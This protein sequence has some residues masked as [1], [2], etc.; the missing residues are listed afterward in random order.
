MLASIGAA[1]RDVEV[2]E[3]A[4]SEHPA[5]RSLYDA[6][7]RALTGAVA[8]TPYFW[9]RIHEPFGEDA[10]AFLVEGD[11]GPEGY[12]VITY[13][14]SPSPLAPAESPSATQWP[15]RLGRR[16]ASCACWRITARSPARRQSRVALATSCSVA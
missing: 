12:A 1:S 5:I 7:A 6:N 8:R 3:V 2:R 13:R 16:A 15:A 11:A 14:P 4:S 10:R 9:V